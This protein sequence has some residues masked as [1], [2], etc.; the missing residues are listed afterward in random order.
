MA[1]DH[2][3]PVEAE[4]ETADADVDAGADAYVSPAADFL[5]LFAVCSVALLG[6]AVVMTP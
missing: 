2:A 6:V 4:T 3:A 1:T 5:V